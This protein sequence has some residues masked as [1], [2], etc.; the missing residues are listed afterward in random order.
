[1]N[2]FGVD[3]EMR[4][5]GRLRPFNVRRCDEQEMMGERQ[6]GADRAIGGMLVGVVTPR[7]PLGLRRRRDDGAAN[8]G[9]AGLDGWRRLGGFRMPMPERQRKLDRERKQRQPRAMLEVSSE[10]VHE[11]CALFP[12]GPWPGP[13]D[14][15]L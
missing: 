2:E 9:E 7:L 3:S 4:R 1:M 10:P 15:T 6:H 8:I 11:T 13:V 14:V 12:G 5:P